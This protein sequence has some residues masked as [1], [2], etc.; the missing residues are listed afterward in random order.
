MTDDKQITKNQHWIPKFYLKGFVDKSI[1]KPTFWVYELKDILTKSLNPKD[2]TPKSFASEEFFYESKDLSIN[3]TENL[4]QEV[5]DKFSSILSSKVSTQSELTAEDKMWVSLFVSVFE[6]RTPASKEHWNKQFGQVLEQ[7]Q[8]L[9]EQFKNGEKSDLHKHIEE[10][11]SNNGFF[12]MSLLTALQVNRWNK[13]SFLFLSIDDKS[14]YHFITSNHPVCLYDMS[15]MNTIY[16]IHPQSPTLEL[17][18]PLSPKLALMINNAGQE[19]YK[20]I[21]HHINYV[22][23]VNNRTII[24]GSE[25]LISSTKVDLTFFERTIQRQRQSLLL[26][27][28]RDEVMKERETKKHPYRLRLRFNFEP[29]SKSNSLVRLFTF[30]LKSIRRLMNWSNN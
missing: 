8:S 14:K 24:Q 4:L 10:E 30:I 6:V 25:F 16:G 22:E 29:H 9:E 28:A 27:N 5:E 3:T 21:S 26:L 12:T 11:I 7:V 23:E 20:D 18:I 17:T 13:A 19:G 2:K 1:K 15:Y